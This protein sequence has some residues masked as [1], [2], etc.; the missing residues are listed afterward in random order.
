MAYEN[1]EI[2][3]PNFCVGPQAGTYCMVDTAGTEPFMRVKNSSGALIT[4]YSFYPHHTM[5]ED[6]AGDVVDG[7][8][9][10]IKYIG[11]LNQASYY[12]GLTFYTLENYYTGLGWVCDI[13]QWKLNDVMNRL[14]LYSSI[15][16]NETP[17]VSYKTNAMAI[18]RIDTTLSA[19]VPGGAGDITLTSSSGIELYDTIMLGPSTDTDNLGA[20]EYMYVK[21]VSGDDVKVRTYEGYVPPFYEYASGDSAIIFRDIFT[22]SAPKDEYSPGVVS[23]LDQRNYGLT[24]NTDSSGL[25]SFVDGADWHSGYGYLTFSRRSAI[26]MTDPNDIVNPYQI[27]KAMTTLNVE[28]D[29]NTIVDIYEIVFYGN[30]LYKLQDRTVKRDDLGNVDV[31]SWLSYNFQTDSIIPYTAYISVIMDDA[32]ISRLE[33]RD[34]TVKVV[35]QFGVSLQNKTVYFY[36]HSGDVDASFDHDTVLTDINGIATNVYNAGGSYTGPVT[37]QVKTDGCS[38]SITGSQYIYCSITVNCRSSFL[39]ADSLLEQTFFYGDYDGQAQD[40]IIE[41]ITSLDEAVDNIEQLPTDFIS[42]HLFHQVDDREEGTF[43]IGQGFDNEKEVALEQ[44]GYSSEFD[45][46]QVFISRHIGGAPNQDTAALDQYDFVAEAIP[47]FWSTKNS[48]A[49]DIWIKI[50]PFAADLDTNTFSYKVREKS[51]AG[52]SGWVDITSQG[53][54]TTFAAGGGLLGLEFFREMPNDDWWFH[55]SGIVYVHIEVYDK[56]LIPNKITLDYWFVLIPDFVTPYI[57]NENP[58]IE[59]YDVPI[60]TNI[61][62][63]VIDTGAGVGMDTMEIF[64]DQ[65]SAIGFTYTTISGGYHVVYDPTN[66]FYYGRTVQVTVN[67]DDLSGNTNILYHVWNFHVIGSTGPWFDRFHYEPGLCIE[68]VDRKKRDISLQV[69]GIDD[70][71]VDNRSIEVHIGGI[72]RKVSINPVVYREE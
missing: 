41:Q 63:D 46:S 39:S 40:N 1:I 3:E 70:H 55:Y 58:E 2:S 66:D 20:T 21:A 24:L 62:F 67:V 37:I 13:R 14:E 45:I 57:I 17:V 23:R 48:I 4:S 44:S 64:L 50:R 32:I 12:S 38:E 33:S 68:G 10:A 27:I 18:E 60:D 65:R 51:Y 56:A 59:D 9:K 5:Y 49:T 7:L 42:T 28:D 19:S 6:G 69:Y 30:T 54:I 16:K 47:A 29:N 31:S 11:P 61:E 52:D 26:Y 36:E 25:Y 35:D 34:I 22:F 53:T 71:G 8:V 72:R 43:S 15:T